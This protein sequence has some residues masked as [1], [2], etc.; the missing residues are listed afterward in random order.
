[1]EIKACDSEMDSAHFPVMLF[2]LSS[3]GRMRASHCLAQNETVPPSPV[4]WAVLL[5]G[6]QGSPKAQPRA[7]LER[8]G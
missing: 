2:Y 3:M 6:K 5:L 8:Q 7:F 1:M 4:V